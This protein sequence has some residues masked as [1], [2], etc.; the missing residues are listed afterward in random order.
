M[1]KG[2]IASGSSNSAP[3]QPM[4]Q[5]PGPTKDAASSRPL[6]SEPGATSFLHVMRTEALAGR[7]CI[8]VPAETAV[9]KLLLSAWKGEVGVRE[10]LSEC[11]GSG[12]RGGGGGERR[13]GRDPRQN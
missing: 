9:P 5:P 1:T 6:S 4:A 3:S 7:V 12:S 8:S 10:E 11:G 13:G 2:G